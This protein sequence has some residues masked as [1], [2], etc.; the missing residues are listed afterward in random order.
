[1]LHCKYNWFLADRFSNFMS[2]YKLFAF[3]AFCCVVGFYS[4]LY[5]F[6][7]IYE[8]N[9]TVYKKNELIIFGFAYICL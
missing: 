1:M 4:Y 8:I 3:G 5:A 7:T 9:A 2:G 6:K